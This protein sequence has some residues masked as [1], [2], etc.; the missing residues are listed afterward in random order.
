[1]SPM[2]TNGPTHRTLSPLLIMGSPRSGTTFLANMVN[3]FFDM[4]VSRGIDATAQCPFG[5]LALREHA[6]ETAALRNMI[7]HDE[8]G[9]GAGMMRGAEGLARVDLDGVAAMLVALMAAMD[10]EAPGAHAPALLLRQRDPILV[11]DGLDAERSQL[12]AICRL[13]DQVENEIRSQG[14]RQIDRALDARSPEIEQGDGE[15]R[16]LL[17][18]IECERNPFRRLDRSLKDD[19]SRA[20]RRLFDGD[21]GEAHALP[22]ACVALSSVSTSSSRSQRLSRWTCAS[23]ASSAVTLPLLSFFTRSSS[24]M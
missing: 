21:S 3:R 17:L 19:L 2:S 11:L 8:A 5:Q 14:R 15:R 4:R 1:M 9:L 7:E 22:L 18:G 16:G 6:Y 20:A 13:A 23:S 12:L 24:L 10:D